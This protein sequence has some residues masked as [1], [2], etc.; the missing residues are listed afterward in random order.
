MEPD[1]IQLDDQA[2]IAELAG[3]VVDRGAPEEM[4]IFSEVATE[5]FRDPQRSLRNGGKDE[6]L[7]FG[8]D[9]VL[10]GPYA[11]AV[12]TPVVQFLGSIA[13]DVAKGVIK[14]LAKDSAKVVLARLVRRMFRSVQPTDGEPPIALSEGQI[15]QVRDTTFE[16]AVALGLTDE[17]AGLLADATAGS[18]HQQPR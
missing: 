15:R 6:P 1:Q 14:D 4:P 2:L 11:L 10:L 16:K 3:L 7:G 12:A 5:Y 9:L 18:L 13:A 17:R 8:V